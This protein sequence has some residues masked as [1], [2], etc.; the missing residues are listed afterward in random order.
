MRRPSTTLLPPHQ[1][2]RFLR[3]ALKTRAWFLDCSSSYIPT[4]KRDLVVS[5]GIPSVA[6]ACIDLE[7][8]T[9][10]GDTRDF[11]KVVPRPAPKAGKKHAQV[12]QRY[13]LHPR[14]HHLLKVVHHLKSNPVLPFLIICG[15]NS[16]RPDFFETI[17][18]NVSNLPLFLKHRIMGELPNLSE[19]NRH[20][21]PQAVRI[22]QHIRK[23]ISVL[24]IFVLSSTLL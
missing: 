4:E 14:S 19:I 16:L 18:T 24:F 13:N 21:E 20:M 1:Y 5:L 10:D 9:G 8:D 12:R 2:E 22:M 7:D 6:E 15:C 11:V 17:P 3:E 23:V